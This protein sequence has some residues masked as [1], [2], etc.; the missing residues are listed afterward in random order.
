MKYYTY[1]QL[2]LI[3]QYYFSNSLF[4]FSKEYDK[5]FN[6]YPCGI[7]KFYVVSM[8]TFIDKF[9]DINKVK[10]FVRCAKCSDRTA[11]LIYPIDCNV[12]CNNYVKTVKV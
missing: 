10:I 12:A 2:D 1:E 5:R 3:T 7:N 6:C 8:E 4:G 9:D 11:E